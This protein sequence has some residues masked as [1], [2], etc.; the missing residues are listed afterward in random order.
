MSPSEYGTHIYPLLT[1]V[2]NTTGDVVE[3]GCGDFST[4]LLHT[5]CKTLGRNL[6]SADTDK[7]WLNLFADFRTMTH[8]FIYVPVYETQPPNGNMWDC[9]SDKKHYGVVFIDHRPGERRA[10]DIWRL[11]N[12]ADI[13]VI[14]DTENPGY[15]Y[16]EVFKHFCYRYDHERYNVKTTLVSNKID[17]SKLFLDEYL[18]DVSPPITRLG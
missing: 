9:I 8:E 13:L 3:F 11:R 12:A 17:V 14:H 10:V 5:I 7:K 16:E 6:T 4:P 18:D 15:G 1:A 2:M